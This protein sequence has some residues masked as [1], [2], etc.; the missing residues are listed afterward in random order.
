M[1][2]FF[3]TPIL[4]TIIIVL[5]ILCFSLAYFH[6]FIISDF[7]FFL[8]C[9]LLRY[10]ETWNLPYPPHIVTYAKKMLSG[11]LYAIEGVLPNKVTMI[12]IAEMTL[13]SL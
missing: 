8:L 1:I 6:K 10:H 13:S 9:T 2:N 3:M 12:M 7:S 11:G 4:S 5:G